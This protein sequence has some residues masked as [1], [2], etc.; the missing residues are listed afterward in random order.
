MQP[1]ILMGSNSHASAAGESRRL[2]VAR[3][4]L[5]NRVRE[6][7]THGSVGG[8]GGQPRPLPGSARPSRSGLQSNVLV[9]RVVIGTFGITMRRRTKYALSIGV[10]GVVAVLLMTATVSRR[11]AVGFTLLGYRAESGGAMSAMFEV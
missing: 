1:C 5:T 6:Y 11:Q 9:G 2:L 8:V 4:V 3:P 10:I 7:F